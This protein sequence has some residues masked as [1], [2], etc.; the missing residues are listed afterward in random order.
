MYHHPAATPHH[1]SPHHPG[2]AA[3]VAHHP[4]AAVSAHQPPQ[5]QQQYDMNLESLNP[6]SDFSIPSLSEFL[7][8]P[9]ASFSASASVDDHSAHHAQPAAAHHL[10][11]HHHAAA[12]HQLPPAAHHPHH[13]AAHMQFEPQIDGTFDPTSIGEQSLDGSGSGRGRGLQSHHPGEE[14]IV[15]EP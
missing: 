3:P 9:G 1:P 13:A 15:D 12:A 14:Q 5:Q 4:A 6:S 8:N 11:A 10:Y 7:D 2:I